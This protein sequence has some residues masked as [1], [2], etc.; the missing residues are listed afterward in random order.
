MAPQ[1]FRTL[2]CLAM[3]GL[4]GT[5]AP[6]APAK[7]KNA[8]LSAANTITAAETKT[9]V[10]VLADDSFEG[11]EANSRGGR[12]AGG[13]LADELRKLGLKGLGDD[14][15]YFQTFSGGRN[16][17][18]YLEGSDP[19]L[20][21]QYVMIGA[22]YDHVGYGSRSNSFGP[23]GYIHNGA[24]D[25]ASG[26]AGLL[27]IIGAYMALPEHPKRS[28]VFALW[29]GEEK[30]LLGSKQWLRTPTIP[31]SSIVLY[32]NMDMIGRMRNSKVEVYGT[33]TSSGLRSLV[34]RH[35][36]ANSLVLDFTWEMKENSDHYS[37]YERNIPAMM[38]HTGLHDNYH[39]PSDDAHLINHQGIEQLSQLVFGFSYAAANRD[40]R[41]TFRN[42]SRREDPAARRAFEQTISQP[43]PRFG[44]QWQE[45]KEGQ[46]GVTITKVTAG[47]P[48][49]KAGLQAGDRLMKFNGQPVT[50]D[51]SLRMAVLL[52]EP[53]AE[54]EV[55]RVGAEAPLTLPVQLDGSP[56]RLGI[57][58][59][60]D[61]ADPSAAVLTQVV[62]G[63]PAY[64]AGLRE[65][66][67]VYELGGQTYR[68]SE[69]LFQLATTLP[70]PIDV[71]V[72]RAGVLRRLTIELPAA[73]PAAVATVD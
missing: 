10:D 32:I 17:L 28:V 65:R 56:I 26:V 6:W 20:K 61:P 12:A 55:Q 8:V 18:A 11:R 23:T 29:D 1:Q 14:G 41:L 31:P 47:L 5:L 38:F 42:E 40:E 50:G 34:S 24:D 71:L 69:E 27:E 67:R 39:R 54:V 49:D 48:G 3:A 45:A 68:S 63:S 35:N 57:G 51:M 44:V 60:E 70:S 66:D 30:G 19:E 9:H 22:H 21:K 15:S 73:T 25:N 13:Y 37:F 58:W 53:A 46:V 33:R 59:R 64:A 16:I 52:A 36:E 72:E 43:G 4:L 2:L 7:E 62:Y